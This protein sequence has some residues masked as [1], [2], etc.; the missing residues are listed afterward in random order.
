[1]VALGNCLTSVFAGFV[2]FSYVGSLSKTLGVP[3]EDVAKSGPSLAFIIYPYAVTQLPVA[4]LWSILFFL[5]LITLGVDSQVSLTVII[6][7]EKV[8][9]V[10]YFFMLNSKQH[11]IYLAHRC[12]NAHND[13]HFNN[14]VQD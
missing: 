5:M 4:P 8:C 10:D 9:P 6:H 12:L 13:W 2:I 11:E 14:Y 3:I 1:M 7:E